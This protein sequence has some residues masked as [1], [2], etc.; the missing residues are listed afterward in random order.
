[1]TSLL[2]G[3]AREHFFKGYFMDFSSLLIK[4]VIF[5]V[6]LIIGYCSAHRGMLSPAFARSASWLLL[7]VF[8]VSSIVSSVLGSRPELPAR[9]VWI[10]M[11]VVSAG[12]IYLYAIAAICMKL[13]GSAQAPQTL[14]LM[15]AVNSLFVG[16]PVVQTVF[17]SEAVFYMGLSCIPFNIL[18]YSYGVG[19]LK[20]GSGSSKVRI[21]DVISAPL[22]AALVS[23]LIFILRIPMPRLI[24]ELF[25]TVSAATVP[26][27]MIVVGAT[28][29]PV[30]LKTA[31]SAKKILLLSFIRLIAAPVLAYFL[32]KLFV[33]NEVL[34][35][36][37]VVIIGCPSGAV[38]TPLSI[39]YGYDPAYASEMI[40]VST[41]L[42]MI[43]LPLLLFIL[44]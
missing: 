30:S 41:A 31:F 29:G 9:E 14:I 22:I 19:C 42:S 36:T 5:A 24:T 40:M 15:G 16:L 33:Q 10:A 35:L 38:N 4:M 7:N 21:R 3:H 2:P 23:L 17:G 39:Q 12:M 6:L 43:T 13:D 18:L 28:L 11:L 37:T 8:L 25:S 34:L 26:L 1:M 20:K 27:S 32:L 44:F